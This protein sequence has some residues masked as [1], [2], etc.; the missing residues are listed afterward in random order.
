VAFLLTVFLFV[1][2]DLILGR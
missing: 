1:T 2:V